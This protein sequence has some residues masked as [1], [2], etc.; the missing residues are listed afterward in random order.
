MSFVSGME[1]L[2]AYLELWGKRPIEAYV[3]LETSDSETVLVGRDGSLV[4]F[5]RVDGCLEVKADKEFGAVVV[6]M[7]EAM[8]PLVDRPGADIEI[9]FGWDP[10]EGGRVSEDLVR[11]V[12]VAAENLGLDLNDV[13]EERKRHLS[14]HIAWESC[15]AVVWTRPSALAKSELD[16]AQKRAQERKWVKAPNAQFPFQAIDELRSR[17]RGLSLGVLGALE[18]A[19]LKAE[20]VEVH[21]AL[22]EVKGGIYIDK[23]N[24]GWRAVLPGDPIPARMPAPGTNDASDILWPSLRRQICND[25]AEEVAT[26]VVRIGDRI[27]TPIDMTLGPQNPAWFNGLLRQAR[28]SGTPFRISIKVGSAGLSGQSLRKLAASVLGITNSENKLIKDGIE[29]MIL[30]SQSEPVV[31]LRISLATWAK[32]GEER[33]L[34]SRVANLMQAVEN[35][36][37]CQC[38]VVDGDP[39]EGAMSSALG[40][41]CNSTAVPAA[42][43][44]SDVVKMFPLQRSASPYRRGAHVFRTAD[45]KAWPYQPGGTA[46]D[47]TF[48]LIFAPPRRGKSVLMGALNMATILS[49]PSDKMPYIAIIDIGFS[50]EGLISLLKE[51]LPVHRR[52]EAGYFRLKMS[53]DHAINPFDTQLGLRFPVANEKA[54]LRNL[55]TTLATPPGQ[56]SSYDGMSELIGL[57]IDEMYR[58]R[59]DFSQGEQLEANAQPNR[60]T[61]GLD[62]KVDDALGA[63]NVQL[64]VKALWWDVVDAL[65]DAGAI[66][67]AGLAQRYAM[68]VLADA[69]DAARRPQVRDMLER[70]TVGSGSE[71]VIDA[72]TR[73]ING[74]ISEYPILAG[75]T[76][77]DIGDTRV[78]SLDLQD[79]APQGGPAEE[80]QTGIMYMLARHVLVHHW[81]L[82]KDMPLSA[83][84]RYREHHLRRVEEIRELPKRL[85]YDELHRTP[86]GGGV[87][88]QI[89]RDGR[90]GPKW[91]VQVGVASQILADFDDDMVKLATGVWVLGAGLSAE[92]VK[93]VGDKF[94]LGPTARYIVQHRLTGPGEGGAPLLQILSGNEGRYVNY[95]VNTLGPIEM[96]ALSTTPVDTQI[97]RRLYDR[98]DPKRA[99]QLLSHMFPGGSAKKEVDRRAAIRAERGITE[100]DAE[101]SV[102]EEIVAEML[103]RAA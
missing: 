25:G 96:W 66:H 12:S 7:V 45:G 78:C 83:P 42:A 67:E 46:V 61:P 23:R 59:S 8:K 89:L 95:L 11:P 50:S 36:G 43:P 39:L 37:Y 86:K 49:A 98:L 71:T 63:Y 80:K 57:V 93:E 88:A 84:E 29:S 64:P 97:R 79:V 18:S 16:R 55:L 3:D 102:V 27:W 100:H 26:D 72:F 41:S 87:R 85:S 30:R 47:Y 76:K 44:I 21:A 22:A 52:H 34:E 62:R 77:F 82:D 5:I 74:A 60:Y 13:L 24:A 92:A 56:Q 58:W 14:R 35:W 81:W 15:Y 54:Y 19:G 51:A 20:V 6:S 32:V 40:V 103:A 75:A 73:M 69:I 101:G 48:D 17:H 10:D 9:W 90:E 1:R 94:D 65:F 99:R 68:P 31:R 70:T 2:L 53:A 4:S 91:N 38:A 28:G 33:L